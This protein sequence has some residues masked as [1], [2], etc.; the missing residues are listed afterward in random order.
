MIIY[1]FIIQGT[2]GTTLR[3]HFAAIETEQP[4]KLPLQKAV[5]SGDWAEI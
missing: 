3:M 5:D 4:N 1:S 2:I